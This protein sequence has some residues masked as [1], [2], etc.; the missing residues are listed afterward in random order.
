LEPDAIALQPFPVPLME[1]E[2]VQP[3]LVLQLSL[4]LSPPAVVTVCLTTSE[5]SLAL[6]PRVL[7]PPTPLVTVAIRPG[8]ST[9]AVIV[10]PILI[11]LWIES[12]LVLLPALVFEPSLLAIPAL[13][14]LPSSI[15]I[16][17]ARRVPLT[18]L[19]IVLPL[20]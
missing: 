7:F 19:L 15:I 8:S 6:T 10:A 14:D 2:I 5:L 16:L 13:V 1:P 20:I 11:T 4:A 18:S 17:A 12:P 9:R 3:S